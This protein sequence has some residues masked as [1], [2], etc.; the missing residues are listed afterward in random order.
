MLA[1]GAGQPVTRHDVVRRVQRPR[2][3][4]DARL[5]PAVRRPGRP[6]RD[7]RRDVG[8]LPAVAPGARQRALRLP[9][10]FDAR[11]ADSERRFVRPL[12]RF[13]HV[14]R[15]L[16]PVAVCRRPGLF[17]RDTTGRP[18]AR[19][20]ATSDPGITFVGLADYDVH[21]SDL[22]NVLLLARSRC[23]RAGR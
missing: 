2:A 7:I 10:R 4:L 18:S 8:R 14:R 12:G 16:G 22:N 9:G 15:R 13:R 11:R 5:R 6:D 23:P 3:R 19:K 1:D 17:R 21:Y 20:C